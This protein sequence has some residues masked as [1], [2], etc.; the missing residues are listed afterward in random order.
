MIFKKFLSMKT[1]YL[2]MMTLLMEIKKIIIDLIDRTDFNFDRKIYDDSDDAK[3][4]IV[5][6]EFKKKQSQKLKMKRSSRKKLLR[7]LQ[8]QRMNSMPRRKN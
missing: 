3:M 8:F 1:I 2:I 7:I 6:E 4:E 5:K